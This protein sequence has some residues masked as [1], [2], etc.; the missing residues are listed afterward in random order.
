M[1][2]RGILNQI[3][4]SGNEAEV[5]LIVLKLNEALASKIARQSKIS[6][7][8][9]YDTLNKLAEKGLITYVIK[10]NKKYFK[11]VDPNKLLD[12]LTEKEQNLKTILP[13]LQELYKPLKETLKIEVYEGAEGLKSIL[14][15]IVK[16][17]KEIAAFGASDRIRSYLPDFIVERYLKERE[18]K[19]IKARQLFT[20][21]TKV[22][23][24]KISTFKPLPKEFS[25]PTTT[26]IYGNKVAIFI[27]IRFPTVILIENKDLAESY[28]KHFKLMWKSVVKLQV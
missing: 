4:L 6:R 16:T 22:L 9:I 27:W 15:D 1:I 2:N 19:K 14:N 5:Y 21:G 8:H 17:G 25:S 12:Y 28:K 24:T 26:V 18:K 20:E 7:P 11:A 10:S 23:K 13:E 3:G